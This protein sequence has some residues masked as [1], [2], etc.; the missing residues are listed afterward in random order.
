M[1]SPLKHLSLVHESENQLRTGLLVLSS[2]AVT[3]TMQE[4]SAVVALFVGLATLVFILIQ[5]AFLMRKWW[6]LEK[7]DWKSN[8]GN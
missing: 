6:R 7:S 4:F 3:W 1:F 8:Q 2:A 5:A